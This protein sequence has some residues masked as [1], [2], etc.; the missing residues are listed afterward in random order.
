MQMPALLN[1]SLATFTETGSTVQVRSI[2]DLIAQGIP[3]PSFIKCDVEG[4]GPQVIS[5][6][7]WLIREYRPLWLLEIWSN[8]EI[9]NMEA[10]GYDCYRYPIRGGSIHQVHGREG[11]TSSYFFL[12]RS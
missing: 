8:E 11:T 10:L 3:R 7:S 9:H 6:A 2:D 5:G 4:N 1:H 12:P